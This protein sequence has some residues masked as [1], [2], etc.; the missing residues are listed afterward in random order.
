M[1]ERERERERETFANPAIPC[2]NG[3]RISESVE[4]LINVMD[5]ENAHSD[6]ITHTSEEGHRALRWSKA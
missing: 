2:T 1:R 4:L 6:W 5:A 3:C